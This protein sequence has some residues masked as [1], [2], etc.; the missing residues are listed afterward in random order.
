MG[1]KVAQGASV[2]E[3][4]YTKFLSLYEFF[5]DNWSAHAERPIRSLQKYAMQDVS[6]LNSRTRDPDTVT[7]TRPAAFMTQVVPFATI[8]EASSL[9]SSKLLTALNRGVGI[10]CRIIN[11]FA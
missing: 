10:L 6:P 9:A 4:Q 3:C 2:R 1:G 7:D 5:D 11:S 8:L